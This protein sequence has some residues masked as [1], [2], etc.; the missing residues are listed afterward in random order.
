MVLLNADTLEYMKVEAKDY[1]YDSFFHCQS[2]SEVSFVAMRMNFKEI[3]EYQMKYQ[4]VEYL[5]M[6]C[7]KHLEEN[8]TQMR[9]IE[10][11]KKFSHHIS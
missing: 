7:V 4:S 11:R 1:M 9:R 8:K 10:F 5:P 3:Y 6:Q 2:P